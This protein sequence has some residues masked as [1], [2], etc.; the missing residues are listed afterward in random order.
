MPSSQLRRIHA[1]DSAAIVSSLLRPPFSKYTKSLQALSIHFTC[2][3]AETL[4][5]FIRLC[6]ATASTLEWI[7]FNDYMPNE[8]DY[9][10][11]ETILFRGLSPPP[12]F[13]TLTHLSLCVDKDFRHTLFSPAWLVPTLC[14]KIIPPSVSPALKCV[15]I[16]VF[17]FSGEHPDQHPGEESP[18]GN[19]NEEGEGGPLDEGVLS[20]LDAAVTGNAAIKT[21]AWRLRDA[22]RIWQHDYKKCVTLDA[23]RFA[24]AVQRM[25]PKIH[26][27]GILSTEVEQWEADVMLG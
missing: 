23:A 14:S 8:S 1:P 16:G 12:H 18:S 13:N 6:H 27:K 21:V 10:I 26:T 20:Q 5:Q 25:L 11:D 17:L 19:P 2:A 24:T 3:S 7:D 15:T 22:T 9:S 4:G